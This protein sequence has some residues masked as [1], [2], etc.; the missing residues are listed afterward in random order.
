MPTDEHMHDTNLS[1]KPIHVMKTFE[2]IK[3]RG[4]QGNRTIYAVVEDAFDEFTLF[5]VYSSEK[6]ATEAKD[7]LRELDPYCFCYVEE[8]ELDEL[9]IY[10][11]Q[12][13]KWMEKYHEEAKEWKKKDSE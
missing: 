9:T 7:E 6:K 2:P 8:Y 13:R 12:Q 11:K 1:K 5:G 10:G 3:E 4:M